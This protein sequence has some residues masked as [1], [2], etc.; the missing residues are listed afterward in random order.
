MAAALHVA[1][2][3][4]GASVAVSARRSSLV[5]ER[6]LLVRQQSR[7]CSDM[8]C[9]MPCSFS[10]RLRLSTAMATA[11]GR[12]APAGGH[13]GRLGTRRAIQRRAQRSARVHGCSAP[14]GMAVCVAALVILVL[15]E[16][17]PNASR[18]VGTAAFALVRR[19]ARRVHRA[20][21]SRDDQ[22]G[23]GIAVRRGRIDTQPHARAR[24]QPWRRQCVVD[25]IVAARRPND[26]LP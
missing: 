7:S 24:H 13:S 1:A 22:G 11:P 17:D 20:Q 8:R 3:P 15:A 16:A 4:A 10:C 12:R 25:I 9:S 19:R 6:R 14:G 18:L 21:Q 26:R 2:G 23:A 5:P